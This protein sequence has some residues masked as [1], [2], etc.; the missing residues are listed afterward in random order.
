M[1]YLIE[2]GDAHYRHGQFGLALKKYV[3][4]QKVRVSRNCA[5]CNI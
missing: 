4:V 5:L 2:Q 3:A 1:L